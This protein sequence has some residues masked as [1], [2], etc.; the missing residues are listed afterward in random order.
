MKQRI[1][2]VSNSSS[3]SFCVFGIVMDRDVVMNLLDEMFGTNEYEVEDFFRGFDIDA[4]SGLDNYSDS[5][6]V[7][8]DVC[9]IS[10]DITLREQRNIIAGKITSIFGKIVP[11]NEVD[12]IVEVGYDG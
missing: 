10:Q 11:P 9:R 5:Y 8:V 4:Y 1:G 7:G 3:T 12:F 6:V 2:F